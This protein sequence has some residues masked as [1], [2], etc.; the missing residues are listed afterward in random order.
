MSELLTALA[1]YAPPLMI[2]LPLL[3]AFFVHFVNMAGTKIRNAFVMLMLLLTGFF[4]YVLHW[5]VLTNGTHRYQFGGAGNN[6]QMILPVV[7]IFFE[8]DAFSVFMSTITI[9]LV[10]VVALY[11]WKFMEKNTGVSKYYTLLFLITTGMLGMQLTGDIFNFFVFLEITSIAAAALVA[12][13]V[14]KAEAV[15]AGFKYIMVSAVGALF[16]LFAIALL[17]GQYNA[18]NMAVLAQS[19]QFGFIDKIALIILLA[20]LAMKAGLV[21]MHM[22]LPDSYGSAPAP[23]SILVVTATLASFYGVIRVLFTIY[24]DAL[25]SVKTTTVFLLPL[26]SVILSMVAVLVVLYGVIKKKQSLITSGLIGILLFSVLFIA[27]FILS[28]PTG[29]S[30]I[31]QST[32]NALIGGILIGL[33]LLTILVGVMMALIQTNLKRLIAFTALAEVGYMFLAI[34]TSLTAYGTTLSHTALTGGLFHIFNDAIDVGLLFLVT[35]AI[36]FMTK[37]H[38]LDKLGGLAHHTK[39]ITILFFIGLYAISGMPP[40]NGFASKIIIYESTYQIN[41]IL[42]IVAIVGSIMILAVFVKVFYAVFMG[43][44]LSSLPKITKVPK[45]MILAMGILAGLIICFGLFPQIVIDHLV[46]PA[47]LALTGG[48]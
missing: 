25:L 43:P 30:M 33:S 39:A 48:I 21:P 3:S 14:G 13:W 35:G 9:S 34:G 32:G 18:L 42:S 20:A 6:P 15:E 17:Y 38:S 10:I 27:T 22:W 31:V 29:M 37:E 28:D 5:D 40:L 44:K 46:T 11:S 26:L 36:Y 2:A 16:V 24:G 1:M 41:P 47:V 12:F 23:V 7:R 19:M 8:I 4:A 45:S